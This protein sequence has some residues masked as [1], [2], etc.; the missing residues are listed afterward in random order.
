METN[1]N[2]VIKSIIDR[3]KKRI[4]VLKIV[5]FQEDERIENAKQEISMLEHEII[6]LN[7]LIDN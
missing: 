4:D 2:E 1:K 7:K 3:S 5:L 6:A